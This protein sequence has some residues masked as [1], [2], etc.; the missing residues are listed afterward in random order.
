MILTV[1]IENA[2]ISI[3]GMEEG[4]LIFSGRIAAELH[5]TTLDYVMS[6]RNVFEV[7]GIHAEDAEGSIIASVVPQLTLPL[8]EALQ[9]LTGKKARV[10]G[11]GLK[12]GL[13]ILMDN[14]A[15]LGSDLVT[16]SVGAAASY[17]GPLVIVS[18]GTATTY[19]VLNERKQYIGGM[20]Q[21]GIQVSLEGLTAKA[22]QL[23]SIGL[24]TPKKLIGTNT[25]D[26]LRSGVIYGAAASIDGMLLRIEEELGC[27]IHAV[28][29]GTYAGLVIPQCSR[30]VIL[31]EQLLFRGLEQIYER[32][33]KQGAER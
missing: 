4:R 22:A 15:Q 28:A 27:R 20:I 14:P 11:P 5:R 21:P 18:L 19:C 1:N 33:R 31:D 17:E 9:I 23:S 12:T 13:S 10:V 25:V 16:L 30:K 7:Y 3:G 8:Q 29:C 32:N 2:I 24:C 26:C 6:L